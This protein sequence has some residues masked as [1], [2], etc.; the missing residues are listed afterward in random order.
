MTRILLI[1]GYG[2]VGKLLARRLARYEKYAI[3]IAGRDLSKALVV[4]K[5][6]GG[7]VK[8]ARYDLNAWDGPN[9]KVIDD[10]DVVV[11]CMDYNGL[12]IISHCIRKGIAYF[13]LSADINH[14]RQVELLESLAIQHRTLV[15]PGHGLCPGLSNLLGRYLVDQ[16]PGLTKVLTGVLLG[17]GERHGPASV[18]WILENFSA[19][20]HYNHL[21]IRPIPDRQKF[22]FPAVRETR[23]AFPFN[24][25]D[26]H[27]LARTYSEKE[28][29]TY[30]ALDP[31][32]VTSLLRLAK[33]IRVDR[34]I[35]HRAFQP[36]IKKTFSSIKIG[37]EV[38]SISC[39][40][41]NGD[42]VLDTISWSGT[43]IAEM[44]AR[45]AATCI[46]KIIDKKETS[47]GVRY[48][49]EMLTLSDV[50][51]DLV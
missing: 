16:H 44:T 39:Y 8:A 32:V 21:A 47:V 18:S 6:L 51:Q 26:Q 19:D 31:D 17:L 10:Q 3:T 48:V 41:K 15:S 29:A 1:G 5:E 9:Q 38:F 2:Q 4:S 14:L 13:D 23:L 36:L 22:Y 25:S 12:A 30:L 34:L 42:E 28:F 11:V 20:F 49:E 35:K 46:A 37:R 33:R 45:V 50:A 27:C 43:N 7:S 40:A 24:F